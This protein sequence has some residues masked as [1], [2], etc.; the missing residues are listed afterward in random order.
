MSGSAVKGWRL[1]LLAGFAS[2]IILLAFGLRLEPGDLPSQL[3]GQP[4][5]DFDLPTLRD[6]EQYLDRQSMVGTH[7][8]L[9]NV[10]ASWCAACVREHPLLMSLSHRDGFHLYGL[11]YKDERQDALDWLAD[12]G[13]P[14]HD[15]ARDADGAVGID[16]GVYGVPE[17]Y[18]L[19]KNGIVLYRHVGP[20]TRADI[21][22]K[23]LPLLTAGDG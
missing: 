10:F 23:V 12:K 3:I 22:N 14:Y 16:F 7:P 17:S 21:N 19:D 6:E 5:P 8:V 20:L 9:L 4:L 18:V 2:L 15:I 13:D 1:A 11:N